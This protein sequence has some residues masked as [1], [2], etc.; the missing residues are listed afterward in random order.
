MTRAVRGRCLIINNE[1]FENDVLPQREGSLID[2]NNLDILFTQ[3]GFKV[4]PRR[5]TALVIPKFD[6]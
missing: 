5:L 3:L 4:R 2:A 6:R 1:T